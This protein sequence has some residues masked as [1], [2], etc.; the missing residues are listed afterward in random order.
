MVARMTELLALKGSETV[1]E[2]GA[3]SGYQTAVLCELARFVYGVEIIPPLAEAARKRL[4]ALGYRTFELACF[5]G[6]HGWPEHAPY[7]A[8]IVAA[9]A[10]RVPALLPA[11]LADGGRL[12][13]PVG[14]REEQR[15]LRIVRQ[16][17]R[18]ETDVDTPCRFVDLVGRYGWGGRPPEA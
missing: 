7:D 17:D 8:I 18:F 4:L 5:D 12:V 9:G 13:I 3:G 10:P 6:T 16:G 15:L 1:L 2:L 14:E 11:Q